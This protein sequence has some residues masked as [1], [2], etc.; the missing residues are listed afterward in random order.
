M[1]TIPVE[2]KLR[3]YSALIEHGLLARAGGCL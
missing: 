1:I 3:P 2:V